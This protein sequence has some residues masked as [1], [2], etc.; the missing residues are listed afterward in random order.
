MRLT[1]LALSL[2]AFGFFST[3]RIAAAP[4]DLKFL[5]GKAEDL[6]TVRCLARDEVVNLAQPRWS[7]LCTILVEGEMPYLTKAE[8]VAENAESERLNDE[9]TA[10]ILSCLNA[11][12]PDREGVPAITSKPL[13][14]TPTGRLGGVTVTQASNLLLVT[15][16]EEV[17]DPLQ[18]L[19]TVRAEDAGIMQTPF[20]YTGLRSRFYLVQGDTATVAAPLAARKMEGSRAAE[21]REFAGIEMVWC[22]PGE[23]LMGSPESEDGRLAFQAE[24]QHR[25]TLTRGFWLA[26]TETT[27]AL[28]ERIAEENPSRFKGSELPVE[29]VSWDN[30]RVWLEKM[31]EAH[32][33]SSGWKW[34]LPTEAQWEYACRAGTEGPFSGERLDAIGWYLVNSGKKTKPVGTKGANPWGLHDMHGNVG[35]WCADAFNAFEDAPVRDPFEE[36]NFAGYVYRGGD[37]DAEAKDCR[38]ATRGSG[39]PDAGYSIIGFRLALSLQGQ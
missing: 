27:Q 14:G 11:G 25:V 36:R 12:A 10:L 6:L 1:P 18:D 22:P 15:P 24:T 19:G 16:A 8:K 3:P 2:L 26:K 33:M 20:S 39:R 4:A 5:A 32:P 38:S 31:N 9:E 7:L 21:A 23:F 35:E 13:T 29:S 34:D 28:W 37:Y 17:A 30:A